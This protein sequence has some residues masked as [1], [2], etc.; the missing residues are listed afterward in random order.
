MSSDKCI[1]D[2]RILLVEDDASTAGAI[3]TVLQWEGY[4]VD[5]AANGQE[6]LN[7]LR[8]PG[9]KPDVI[10]LDIRMPVMDGRQFRE[11]QKRDPIINDIPVVVVSGDVLASSVDASDHIQKPFLPRELLEAIWYQT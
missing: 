11:E 6:A 4:H 5:C 9:L 8:Q 1:L 2:K 10:L 7:Q 3:K